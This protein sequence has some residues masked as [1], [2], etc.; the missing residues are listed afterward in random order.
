[1]CSVVSFVIPILESLAARCAVSALFYICEVTEDGSVLAGI[2]LELPGENAGAVPQRRF[3]WCP[4]WCGRTDAYEQAAIQAIK[5]LQ[6]MYGFVVRDYNY[7]CMLGY[8]ESMRAAVSVAACAACH[9]ARL[10]MSSSVDASLRAP[11]DWHLIRS[12]LLASLRHV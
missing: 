7:D 10:D 3:F 11:F 8:R 9:A 4:V 1:M 2:E 5:F 6:R 12:R